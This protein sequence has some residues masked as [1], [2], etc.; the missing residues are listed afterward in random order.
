[1]NARGRQRIA[2]GLLA[3]AL[4]CAFAREPRAQASAPTAS[5]QQHVRA[6]ER[7]RALDP[8]ERERI[9]ERYGAW[10]ALD[11]EQRRELGAQAR[12]ARREFERELARLTPAQRA[13]YEALEPAEQRALRRERARWNA[14]ARRP[15]G[16][17][18]V[19]RELERA[20][21]AAGVA[22]ALRPSLADLLE[23]RALAPTERR[24]QL[25]ERAR[26]RALDWLERRAAIE[27]AELERLRA[28]GAPELFRELRK[29]ARSDVR[30]APSPAPV[31][32]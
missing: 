6:L 17:R 31:A 27:A 19:A 11:P 28:L 13:R 26:V 24:A 3:L 22:R 9:R 5:S 30:A 8:A 23:L 15:D 29:R 21:F 16:E 7:W 20:A 1:M 10:R 32:R 25:R 12:R 2:A 18:V 4:V 14:P